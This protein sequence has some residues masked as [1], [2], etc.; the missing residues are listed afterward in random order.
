MKPGKRCCSCPQQLIKFY[1][2]FTVKNKHTIWLLWSTFAPSF[3]EI[4]KAESHNA[5]LYYENTSVLPFL[6][7]NVVKM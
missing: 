1:L 3:I 6:K 2:S 7:V 5:W 4:F